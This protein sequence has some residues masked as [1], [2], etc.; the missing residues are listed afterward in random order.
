[1]AQIGL[2]V[3]AERSIT[4]TPASHSQRTHASTTPWAS[5]AFRVAR[6]FLL[7]NRTNYDAAYRDFEWP[8]VDRF[9]WALDW[10]DQIGAGE[11]RNQPA[12]WVVFED[13]TETKFSFLELSSRSVMRLRTTIVFIGYR[14]RR[15][16]HGHAWKRSFHFGIPFWP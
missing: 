12:L 5:D 11:R 10:F 15:S 4:F 9:N 6:D 14:P 1:M 16:R 13:G 2:H 7:A 8:K 3:K